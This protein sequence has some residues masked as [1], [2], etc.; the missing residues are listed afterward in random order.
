VGSACGSPTI[1]P[2]CWGRE[3]VATWRTIDALLFPSPPGTPPTPKALPGDQPPGARPRRPR[4][5]CRRDDLVL[6][7]R[8]LTATFDDDPAKPGVELARF[9]AARLGRTRR[10]PADRLL[11]PDRGDDLK[12]LARAGVVGGLEVLR[13]DR[14]PRDSAN[15]WRVQCR[16]VLAARAGLDPGHP[17][18]TAMPPGWAEIAAKVRPVNRR[19]VAAA[20]AWAH[21]YPRFLLG[22]D[23][24]CP[25][26]ALEGEQDTGNV[27]FYHLMRSKFRM[28]T[29]FGIFR[30]RHTRARRFGFL[31]APKPGP[32]T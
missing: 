7:T 17:A 20:V 12:A 8:K 29:R 27:A 25:D 1:C 30:V 3:A 23:A 14:D 21:S 19:V 26:P 5:S 9:V 32:T 10:P 31:K 13:V 24:P 4:G 28:T 11:L 15:R 22:T 6:V 18:L 16:Q 2:H